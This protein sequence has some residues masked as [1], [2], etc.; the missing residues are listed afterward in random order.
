MIGVFYSLSMPI[1]PQR[2]VA[3][4]L[5]KGGLF[6]MA[7]LEPALAAQGLTGRQYLVLAAIADRPISQRALAGQA[8]VDTSVLVGVLDDLEARSLVRRG[9]D[10]EDR[11]RQ[12]L[13]LTKLGTSTINA[14]AK[15]SAAAEREFLGTLSRADQSVLADLLGRV[16]G[17]H[18]PPRSTEV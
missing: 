16:V 9:A 4:L 13:S 3:Y 5:H 6:V 10:P 12:R 1:D 11:R 15:A 18:L 8:G 17:P 14:A 2:S 7:A